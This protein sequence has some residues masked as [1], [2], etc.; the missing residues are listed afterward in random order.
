MRSQQDRAGG[1][2]QLRRQPAQRCDEVI[3]DLRFMLSCARRRITAPPRDWGEPAGEEHITPEI[4]VDPPADNCLH[5]HHVI[6]PP[7]KG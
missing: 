1:D 2:L 4:S 3:R 6:P 5:C 7:A